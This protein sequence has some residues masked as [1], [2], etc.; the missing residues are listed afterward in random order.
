MTSLDPMTLLP[1]ISTVLNSSEEPSIE[2]SESDS[3]LSSCPRR[4]LKDEDLLSALLMRFEELNNRVAEYGVE[5]ERYRS[6]EEKKTTRPSK[7]QRRAAANRLRETLGDGA[8]FEG[9]HAGRNLT[10]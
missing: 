4:K 5:D 10:K 2:T 8:G 6:I 3:T 7:R 9:R 1:P